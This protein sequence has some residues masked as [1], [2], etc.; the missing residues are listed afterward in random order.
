MQLF[1][2]AVC[3]NV[4]I[5]MIPRSATETLRVAQAAD[6]PIILLSTLPEVRVTLF[7]A[8]SLS[9]SLVH[10]DGL[11][12]KGVIVETSSSSAILLHASLQMNPENRPARRI[13]LDMVSGGKKQAPRHGSIISPT[14]GDPQISEMMSSDQSQN[15]LFTRRQ[16]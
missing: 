3:F 10:I 1:T 7:I 12:E 2:F 11:Y 5:R 4:L 13:L 8:S 6:D 15:R 14:A 16:Y 9:S